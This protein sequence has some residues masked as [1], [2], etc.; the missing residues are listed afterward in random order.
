[1]QRKYAITFNAESGIAQALRKYCEDN[2]MPVNKVIVETIAEKLR[3]MDV[4]SLSIA[5]IEEIEDGQRQNTD[6]ICNS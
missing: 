3:S 6:W 4:H 5:E 1:M 2:S